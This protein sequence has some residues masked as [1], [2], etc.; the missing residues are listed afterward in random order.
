[1][2]PVKALVPESLHTGLLNAICREGRGGRWISQASVVRAALEE[3][4]KAGMPGF[5]EVARGRLTTRIKT[6]LPEALYGKLQT[7][8][9]RASRARKRR[10]SQ[11]AVVRAALEYRFGGKI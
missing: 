8:A 9:F 3:Y 4:L 6:Y 2:I 11:A 7:A 5:S 10:V 1:L